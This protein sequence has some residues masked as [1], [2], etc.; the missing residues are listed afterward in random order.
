[1]P[2]VAKVALSTN[3]PQL[4]RLF[5]YEIGADENIQLVEGARVKVSLG[6]SG[7]LVEGF[8]VELAT[9]SSFA[10][11]LSVIAQIVDNRP[12]LKKEIL[13]LCRNLADRNATTL[14]ELLRLAIPSHM[15]R[16]VQTHSKQQLDK[17]I[18]PGSQNTVFASD[19]KALQ[20]DSGTLHAVVAR[21]CLVPLD[22]APELVPDWV[23]RFCEVASQNA[24]A[25]LSTILLVPDYREHEVLVRGLELFGLLDLLADYSQDLA[26]SKRYLSFLNCLDNSPIIAVGSRSAAFAPVSNLGAICVYDE[27]DSSFA[28][29]S[30]PFLH[31]RDVVLVRQSIQKC[32][33]LFISH[34][35]SPEIQRLVET[36]YLQES[37][38]HFP[39]PKVS[40]TEPGLRLDNNA[41]RAIKQ[42][43]SKGPVLV[44]V[45]SKGES[46][47]LYC[48]EC[49]QRAMCPSCSGGIWIDSKAD[50]RCRWCNRFAL[51]LECSCGSKDFSLGRAGSSRTTA[52]LGKSFP[53]VRVIE[54]TGEQKISKLA[55]GSFLVIATAGAE[56]YVQ[57]GYQA[58]VLL[59]AKVFL[60]KQT[61][62]SVDES[63]RVW[64]NAVAKLSPEAEAVLVGVP[65]KTGQQFALWNMVEIATS[66]LSARRELE[67][68]PALRLG[69]VAG[70]PLVLEE[71]SAS[72]ESVPGAQAIGPAP[73]F[74]DGQTNQWRLIFKYSYS[75]TMQLAQIL[76]SEIYRLSAGKT[77]KSKSGRNT[78]LLK[79]RMNDYEV[80]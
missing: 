38:L 3:L 52:E 71:L 29:Q 14:G 32:S 47:A 64:A 13:E 65:G 61:L 11:K 39:K 67:L 50:K 57:G 41:F 60:S 69:S 33:L 35:R 9:A 46:V 31:T 63:V 21:P 58:V 78:R 34:S 22:N 36:G 40:V 27:S 72:I 24:Q 10:G 20:P 45:A 8:V 68:P 16:A 28:D 25:G 73:F 74:V 37:T 44:Q 15:P 1:M 59:D 26:K 80:V 17:S 79:V 77:A 75:S 54:S 66:E 5:D 55:A 51:D 2:T 12:I 56:P 6:S 48:S 7:K 53:G 76:R 42:G 18:N 19:S 62:R 49:E 23:K 43:L 30:S 70:D 4:D